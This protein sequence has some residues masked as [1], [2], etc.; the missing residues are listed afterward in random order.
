MSSS[1]PE[2][3]A[4]K[5]RSGRGQAGKGTK[6][7][8]PQFFK[9]GKGQR[10]GSAFSKG[11]QVPTRDAKNT[12]SGTRDGKN[13]LSGQTKKLTRKSGPLARQLRP[14]A[15]PQ[16]RKEPSLAVP[17]GASQVPAEGHQATSSAARKAQSAKPDVSVCA[18]SCHP[19]RAASAKRKCLCWSAG[20]VCGGTILIVWSP[21]LLLCLRAIG[22]V[23]GVLR[24]GA[25]RPR[26]GNT[27]V[28]KVV[29]GQL[30]IAR[31]EALW[32][33]PDNSLHFAGRWFIPPEQT[34]TGRQKHHNA[35][36]V[37]LTQQVDQNEMDTL[38]R[39]VRVLPPAAFA[40]LQ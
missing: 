9:S 27:V 6:A 26:P 1:S 12:L 30:S 21:L 31:L 3:I 35:L 10:G 8:I 16:A 15:P 22:S 20:A 14:R 18:L 28:D 13:H 39:P 5:T 37:F 36:E 33:L 11:K 40:Q 19:S 2:R 7:T 29:G 38:L 32:R 25:P 24:G 23:Q 4:T 34:H 17:Q